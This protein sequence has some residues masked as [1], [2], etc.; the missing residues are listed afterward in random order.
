MYDQTFIQFLW[1]IVSG[2]AII[3]SV[4]G[5]YALAKQTN[6]KPLKWIMSIALIIGVFFVNG[7]PHWSNCDG[8]EICDY[9]SARLLFLFFIYAIWSD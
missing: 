1:V 8:Y 2:T 6:N 9:S 5:I 4:L 7:Q 3:F